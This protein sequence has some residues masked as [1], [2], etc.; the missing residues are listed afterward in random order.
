MPQHAGLGESSRW[1]LTQ[2]RDT[3]GGNANDDLI[4]TAFEHDGTRVGT[5]TIPKGGHGD[6]L[7]MRGDEIGTYV[8]GAWCWLPWRTGTMT[9]AEAQTRR[10]TRALC[11]LPAHEADNDC[12]GEADLGD[13]TWLRLYGQSVKGGADRDPTHATATLEV[14]VA[15]DIVQVLD[16]DHIPRDAKGLPL[17]GRYEPEGLTVATVDGEPYVLAGFSVGQLSSTALNVYGRPLRLVVP[18]TSGS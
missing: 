11:Q 8:G 13:G 1:Y 10:G 15:G 2:G 12:Q 3:T 6:R 4:V 17:G 5:L 16:L 7:V 14:I 18:P 9:V